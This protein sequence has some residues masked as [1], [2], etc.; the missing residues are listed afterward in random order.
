MMVWLKRIKWMLGTFFLMI[1]V[2]FLHYSLPSKDIVKIVG[3]DVKRMDIGNRSWLWASPDAGTQSNFTRDVRFINAAWPGG[4]PRVYR[5]EDTNWSWPPYFKFD[6][7]NLNAETQA[8][9]KQD[10]IW[11]AVTHYGWRIKLLS[12]FPNAITV[13]RVA[14][15]GATLIPYFN[16]AF[17]TVLAVLCFFIF[18]T[19][20]RFKRRRIDP[21][22][23]EVEGAWDAVEDTASDARDSAADAG[24]GL[25]AW[26]R[27]WF[28]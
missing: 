12:M 9:A 8:L 4:A 2:A 5:N 21:V 20:R 6:S 25:R 23:K 26:F 15:P 24:R 7:G 27:K 16:I 19:V 22:L 3:T 14:G 1:V 18:R 28:G 17:F 11:V 13:T 10:D